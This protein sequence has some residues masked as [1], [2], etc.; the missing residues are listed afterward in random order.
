MTMSRT[1]VVLGRHLITCDVAS[2][3]QP[4]LASLN[5]LCWLQASA[6]RLGASVQLRHASPALRDLLAVSGLSDALP[7]EHDLVVESGRQAKEREE[8]GGVEEEDDPGDPIA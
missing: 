4:D 7:C 5:A 8:A 2:I 6:D 3:G 1:K